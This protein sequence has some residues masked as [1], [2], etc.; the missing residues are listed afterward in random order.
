MMAQ[1]TAQGQGRLKPLGVEP[2]D[3]YH[4]YKFGGGCWPRFRIHSP[5]LGFLDSTKLYSSSL[6]TK[7][8]HFRAQARLNVGDK[9]IYDDDVHAGDGEFE[10][11]ELACFRVWSW[12]SLTDE[13]A[14]YVLCLLHAVVTAA[15]IVVSILLQWL[16]V[17]VVCWRRAIC[18]EFM[19]KADVLEY[20]D[21]TVNS[22][23]G[24][25]YI[26]AVLRV[27]S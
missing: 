11:D 12:I 20:Y 17:N 23:S 27:S 25:F 5:K 4:C 13:S 2:K 16:P 26:P 6:N 10:M 24:S 3:P 18:L 1:F 8:N 14:I 15:S 22:P 9:G 21:Q 19:E 7:S